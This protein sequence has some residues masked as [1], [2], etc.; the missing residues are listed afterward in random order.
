MIATVGFFGALGKMV[1]FE[2]LTPATPSMI[3]FVAD[4]NNGDKGNNNSFEGAT[5]CFS[6]LHLKDCATLTSETCVMHL[7]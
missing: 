6:S 4:S 5:P 1:M 7:S 3:A 2:V